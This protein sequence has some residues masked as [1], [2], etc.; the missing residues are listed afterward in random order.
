MLLLV[1][2]IREIVLAL[3]TPGLKSASPYVFGGSG[4]NTNGLAGGLAPTLNCPNEL[5]V[6][7]AEFA[8][9]SPM[10]KVNSSGAVV[11]DDTD[12]AICKRG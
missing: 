11:F 8:A 12:F 5:K 4:L 7:S 2:L 1:K 6:V 9:L 10:P 3:I